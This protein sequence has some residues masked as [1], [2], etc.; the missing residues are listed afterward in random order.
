MFILKMTSVLNTLLIYLF[1]IHDLVMLCLVQQK[2]VGQD[3]LYQRKRS[4]K[5]SKRKTPLFV[6]LVQSG[7]T[8]VII[9]LHVHG[10][11]KKK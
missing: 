7:D 10:H 4:H 3:A 8:L 5:R 9:A 2:E 6:H 1:W 11:E